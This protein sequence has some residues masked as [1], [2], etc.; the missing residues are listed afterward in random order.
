[1]FELCTYADL[2]NALAFSFTQQF[3]FLKFMILSAVFLLNALF[4]QMIA[5]TVYLSE[6]ICVR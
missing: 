3:R 4:E 1:M 6:I 5:Q 2:S